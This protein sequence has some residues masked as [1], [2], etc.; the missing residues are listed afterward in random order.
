[1][2]SS[3]SRQLRLLTGVDAYGRAFEPAGPVRAGKRV[4]MFF[5]LWIGQPYATGV[6]DAERILSSPGGSNTL[7]HKDTTES[8]NGQ[9]H[10]WGQPLFGYY[11]SMDLWVICRQLELLTLAGVD[12][13]VFDATN[14]ITYKNVYLRILAE[15]ERLQANGWQ[16]PK[17]AFYTHSYSMRTTMAL[18][19]ELYRPRIHPDAWY[20]ED[21]KPVVIAY[22]DQEDDKRWAR[23]EMKDDGYDPSCYP[24]EVLDFFRFYKPQW[25]LDPSYP[26]G[27]PWVEWTFPQPLHT[28]V[29]SVSVASHPNVPFSFTLTRG[30][31]NWGRGWD[32]AQ[33]KNCP[34]KVNTGAF[35][36]S[37]WE[38]ALNTDPATVFVGGWNEWIAYKQMWDGEYMMCDAVSR[39]FSRDIEPMRGGYEDAFYLQLITNIRRYKYG[40]FEER[41]PG[42]SMTYYA[43]HPEGLGRDAPGVCEAL[44]YTQ[45]VPPNHIH[46]ITVGCTGGKLTFDAVFQHPV[47]DEDMQ[48][49]QLLLGCGNAKKGGFESYSWHITP[50]P[51]Q[52]ALYLKRLDRSAEEMLQVDHNRCGNR[53]TVEV[54]RHRL[55]AS[56]DSIYFKAAVHV[57]DPGDIM[58]YYTSGS[59]LPPG[60]LS[61]MYRL[62]QQQE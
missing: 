56:Y 24:A 34:D 30:S 47:S 41:S 18:Y 16:P 27:F 20:R 36:Q 57:E 55:G 38:H 54:M 40:P 60:R 19:E 23:R 5:W 13:I 22:T 35:F 1:M 43:I 10:F 46:H 28:D 21:G 14:A 51:G 29:M 25:P 17:A 4:G 6:Y 33:K 50:L 42:E 15:I 2:E 26:D 45:P 8:P 31:E 3:K 32:A 44:R 7:F 11:N 37:Q 52:Q 62:G 58:S 59:A 48:S 49:F 53:L 9:Q 61:Y 12:F 39:E